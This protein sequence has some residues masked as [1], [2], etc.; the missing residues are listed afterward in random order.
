MMTKV[1]DVIQKRY[2]CRKYLKKD[3]EEEKIQRL[4][5]AARLAPSA[6]NR[7]EWRFIVV[8]DEKKRKTLAYA[9][10]EQEFVAEAPVLIVCCAVTNY[11][12]MTCG[13]HC[14]PID[15]AVAVEHIALQAVEEDLGTCWVGAF[16]EYPV[17]KLLGIPDAVRVVELMTVGYPADQPHEK[18]RLP[19]EEII[20][21]EE[22]RED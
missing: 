19:L 9:A 10:K 4:I 5:D 13:Q 22:W 12:M 1:L 11:H 8:K 3:V 20:M 15:L 2:S 17:K 21:L 7:Q 14:Y 18:V 6:K 16:Y